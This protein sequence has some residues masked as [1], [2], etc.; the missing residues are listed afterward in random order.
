MGKSFSD[1]LK[2]FKAE[3]KLTQRGV[4]DVL[5]ISERMY[6]MYE[7]GYQDDQSLTFFIFIH[8]LK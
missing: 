1:L 2:E 6:V 7:K 5:G 8:Q 4:A 3:Y